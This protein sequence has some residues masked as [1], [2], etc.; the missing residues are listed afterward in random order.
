M[1]LF[2]SI[3]LSSLLS[4][5][6]FLT[7]PSLFSPS[8]PLFVSSCL[9]L[10]SPSLSSIIPLSLPPS[11]P[12]THTLSLYPSSSSPP[13][14]PPPPPPLPLSL[15]LSPPLPLSLSLSLSL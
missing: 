7:L 1:S 13:L 12:H 2:P 4:H 14:P 9:Q 11:P 8:N 10:S 3:S 6:L 5:S 15:S